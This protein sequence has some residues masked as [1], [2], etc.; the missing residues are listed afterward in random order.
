VNLRGLC[1]VPRP[2]SEKFSIIKERTVF[3]SNS[4]SNKPPAHYKEELYWKI[5]EKTGRLIL[6]N[7]LSIPIAVVFGIGFFLFIHGFGVPPKFALSDPEVLIFLI[8]IPIVLAFH[9]LLHGVLMQHFGARPSYGFF[10]RGLMFYAKAPGQAFR[11]NQY[12]VIVL[13]PFVSLTISA[14]LGIVILSGTQMVWILAL[15]AVINASAASADLWIIA[16]VLRF[17]AS[18]YV[19]DER[20]GMRIF[21]PQKNDASL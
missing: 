7:L 17:P 14:C 4:F 8:G 1:I 9:E 19:V 15:W 16:I 3:S 5:S 12:L 21:L 18:I 2:I 10:L 20:D 6:M 11:R 13:A